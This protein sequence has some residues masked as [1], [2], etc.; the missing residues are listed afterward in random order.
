MRKSTH[1]YDDQTVT[2]EPTK[3]D[4]TKITVAD[5]KK[6]DL[7][8]QLKVTNDIVEHIRKAEHEAAMRDFKANMVIIDQDLAISQGFYSGLN[9]YPPMV[10]GLEVQ[11]AKN[12]VK[13]LGANFIISRGD[14]VEDRIKKLEA[15]NAELKAKLNKIKDVF[16]YDY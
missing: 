3:A 11:Y 16:G 1:K 10:F 12:L 5:F 13:D 6:L 2:W 8:D 7:E 4:P 15:E 9:L 14:T